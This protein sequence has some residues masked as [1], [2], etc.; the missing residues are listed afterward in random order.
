MTAEAPA[1]SRHATH[2]VEELVAVATRLDLA[3][4][5]RM[6]AEL[7][8]RRAAGGR[9]FFLGVGGGAANAAHAVCDFRGMAGFEAYAPTDNPATLTA[10]INDLGWDGSMARWLSDSQL[11]AR[12]AVV[13]FSV[14]G[15][16]EDPPVSMNL[17][18]AVRTTVQ[19]GAL[20]CGV[21]GPRGGE[22]A[23]SA[24]ICITV[25]VAAA[26][27]TTTHTEI[28]QAVVWHLL[29]THPELNR[30]RPHWEGLG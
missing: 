4:V 16:S 1:P 29:V 30:T 6:A 27:L 22:T 24:D 17:V 9:V 7:G 26:D 20:L 18:H 23:R 8:R 5:D 10:S 11:G 21:V 25:P 3:A 14:G 28:F 12:D 19:T 15:G 2:F 13:V